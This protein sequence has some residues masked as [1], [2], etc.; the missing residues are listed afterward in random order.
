MKKDDQYA[1]TKMTEI[2]VLSGKGLKA[3]M[4]KMVQQVTMKMI[5]RNETQ[6]ERFSEEQKISKRTK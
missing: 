3:G 6:I 2:L 4:I 1:N 5:E